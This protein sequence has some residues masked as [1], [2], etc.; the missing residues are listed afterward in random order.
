MHTNATRSSALSRRISLSKHAQQRTQQ[1]GIAAS[2]IP[3]ILAYGATEHDGCGGVRYLMSAAALQR[4]RS[5]IGWTAQMERLEGCYVV[6]AE[7][8]GTVITA[9]HRF[10]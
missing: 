1:R 10:H 4:L 6:V 5:A 8:D 7:A 3:L 9:G 2:W